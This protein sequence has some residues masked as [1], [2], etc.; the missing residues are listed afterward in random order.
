VGRVKMKLCT[1][2]ELSSFT[3]FG[4]DILEGMPKILGGTEPRPRPLTEIMY[5]ILVA[6]DKLKTCTKFED[7]PTV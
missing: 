1:N 2:F 3:C 4:G 7:D 5:Y 6:R